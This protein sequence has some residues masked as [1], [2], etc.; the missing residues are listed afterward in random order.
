VRGRPEGRI[1]AVASRDSV[2]RP[3]GTR[4]RWG[5]RRT[6]VGRCVTSYVARIPLSVVLDAR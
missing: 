1:R 5:G 4:T 2:G 3:A 6:G